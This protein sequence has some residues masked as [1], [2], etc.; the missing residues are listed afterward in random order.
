MR[1]RSQGGNL[2]RRAWRTNLGLTHHMYGRDH[3]GVG[4]YYGV[5]DAH[6][7]LATVQD[8]LNITPVYSMNW[9]Y[10]PHCG[11]ITSEGICDHKKEWQKF[12]GTVMRS[13]VLD[14]VKPPCLIYR[15]EVFDVMIASGEIVRLRLP[16]RYRQLSRKEDSCFR[17]PAF[18]VGGYTDGRGKISDQYLDQ[19][20]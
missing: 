7:L 20:R 2:S 16:V 8:E 18:E 4:T 10:C 1:R 15:P 19:R 14:G 9:R 11:E 5:Y 3:A 12:S 13:I 17:N 6:H